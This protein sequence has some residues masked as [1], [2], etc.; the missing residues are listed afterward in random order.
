MIKIDLA[1]REFYSLEA[2]SYYAMT[3]PEEK[4]FLP[5]I[6]KWLE[7]FHS[8]RNLFTKKL[9]EAIF[10]YTAKVV[11]GEMGHC[12]RKAD[13]VLDGKYFLNR[14]MM[15]RDHTYS[16]CIDYSARALLECGALIF[17]PAEVNWD[18]AYGG[19]KWHDIAKAGLLRYSLNDIVFIDHCVDLSHNNSV[20]FDKGA[21]IFEFYNLCS[22]YQ[23][24]L[25]VKRDSSPE[26]ILFS[27]HHRSNSCQLLTL[28]GR[29]MI[30]NII[31]EDDYLLFKLSDHLVNYFNR[32]TVKWAIRACEREIPTEMVYDVLKYTPIKWGNKVPPS[33]LVCNENNE[34]MVE[35]IRRN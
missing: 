5:S 26:D 27:E 29:A 12:Y 9:A 6:Q 25:N 22:R 15:A 24:F 7:D 19:E 20:Y 28:L 13:R 11:A 17:N 32:E 16:E 21:G 30:L 4:L 2:L 1:V 35:R 23:E 3:I 31:P 14:E 34:N 8:Y 10:D 18:D 33:K